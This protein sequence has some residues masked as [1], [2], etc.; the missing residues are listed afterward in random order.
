MPRIIMS[1]TQFKYRIKP[2]EALKNEYPQPYYKF[3]DPRVA[4]AFFLETL[5][6]EIKDIPIGRMRQPKTI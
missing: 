2:H 5:G 1:G 6:Q 4:T 3:K